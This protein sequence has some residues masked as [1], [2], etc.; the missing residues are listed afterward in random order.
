MDQT[1]PDH[2]LQ[3]KGAGNAGLR[4]ASRLACCNQVYIGSGGSSPH[5]CHTREARARPQ[6]A[7]PLRALPRAPDACDPADGVWVRVVR[8]TPSRCR[9][10]YGSRAPGPD[11]T[12][13]VERKRHRDAWTGEWSLKVGG[14]C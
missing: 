8:P 6:L 14:A 1:R 10:W 9:R 3:E 12:V 5:W 2:F 11:Q 4:H 7:C 13:F